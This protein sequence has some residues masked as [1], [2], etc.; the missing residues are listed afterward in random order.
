ML[1]LLTAS[2]RFSQ[3]FTKINNMINSVNTINPTNVF[4][5]VN[6]VND[7]DILVYSQSTGL[8]S[9]QHINSFVNQIIT[10][11]KLASSNH[12]YNYFASNQRSLY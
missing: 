8:F 3:W 9:N 2:D 7:G 5:L 6:P 11:N 4:G 10:Q 1:S 12:A